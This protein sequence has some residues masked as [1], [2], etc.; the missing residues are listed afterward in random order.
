VATSDSRVACRAELASVMLV[1]QG[2][3]CGGVG[4]VTAGC[5]DEARDELDSVDRDTRLL[6]ASGGRVAGSELRRS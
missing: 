5:G 4:G 1:M 3:G 2:V 6:R